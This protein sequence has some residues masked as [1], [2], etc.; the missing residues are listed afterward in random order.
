MVKPSRSSRALVGAFARIG[1]WM[2]V[3]PT[4]SSPGRRAAQKC[5]ANGIYTQRRWCGRAD[6]FAIKHGR[7]RARRLDRQLSAGRQGCSGCPSRLGGQLFAFSPSRTACR[8]AADVDFRHPQSGHMFVFA[9][10]VL[11]WRAGYSAVVRPC[12]GPGVDG[13]LPATDESTRSFTSGRHRRRWTGDRLGRSAALLLALAVWLRVG[14]RAPGLRGRTKLIWRE[15]M[16]GWG[17]RPRHRARRSEANGPAPPAPEPS[18]VP[19]PR[20]RE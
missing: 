12:G 20:R 17:S 18:L 1:S 14:G 2:T 11:I 7:L 4:P 6:D 8:P 10:C 13:R 3:G 16:L 15:P 9:C 19:V 5:T